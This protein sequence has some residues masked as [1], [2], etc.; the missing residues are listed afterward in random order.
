LFIICRGFTGIATVFVVTVFGCMAALVAVI[1]IA[2][3]V[4][5]ARGTPVIICI[6]IVIAVI[7]SFTVTVIV[8][9]VVAV[10]MAVFIGGWCIIGG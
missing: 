2:F 7:V 3:I 6:V 4:I 1:C 8:F 9:I 10:I 5:A